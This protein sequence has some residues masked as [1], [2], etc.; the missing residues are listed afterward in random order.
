MRELAPYVYSVCRSELYTALR[1]AAL[2]STIHLSLP[3]ETGCG[4]DVE[5]KL[6]FVA[7]CRRYTIYVLRREFTMPF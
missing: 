3:V 1:F 4:V 6:P 2:K 7:P 5:V